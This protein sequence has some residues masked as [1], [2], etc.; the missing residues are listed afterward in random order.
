MTT[1]AKVEIPTALDAYLVW[2]ILK[3][4]PLI[5][6]HPAWFECEGLREVSGTKVHIEDPSVIALERSPEDLILLSRFKT[7]ER[8]GINQAPGMIYVFEQGEQVGRF[9]Y[10][11]SFNAGEY[12]ER[13]QKVRQGLSADLQPSLD[14]TEVEVKGIDAVLFNEKKRIAVG[15]QPEGI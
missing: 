11:V 1:E 15:G 5:G 8:Q 13:I 7:P 9:L 4:F 10:K 6:P 3:R 2:R 14:L 12:G